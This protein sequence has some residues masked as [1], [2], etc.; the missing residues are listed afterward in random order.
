MPRVFVSIG[1]NID[2]ERN[3]RGAIADLERAYGPLDLSPVYET[4]AQGFDGDPFY[5]LVAAFNSDAP[6]LA[7]SE[8]LAD[9]ER[10]HGRERSHRGFVPRTLDLDLLL[11]GNTVI[12][13]RDVDVPRSEIGQFAFVLRPLAELAPNIRHPETGERL[14]EMWDRFDG[15]RDAFRRVTLDPPLPAT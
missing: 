5:N 13:D 15:E 1:S 14:K 12:R 6:P 8:K 11:Y 10:R 7:I 9:L 2:K 3:I 4:T